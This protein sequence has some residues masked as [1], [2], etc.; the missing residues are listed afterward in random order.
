MPH[1][2]RP[3][4]LPPDDVLLTFDRARGEYLHL[5][6]PVPLRALTCWTAPATIPLPL[7]HTWGAALKPISAQYSPADFHPFETATLSPAPRGEAVIS[8]LNH[9]LEVQIVKTLG[10]GT[11]QARATDVANHIRATLQRLL[12]PVVVTI[13]QPGLGPRLTGADA[14]RWLVERGV[15]DAAV[16][17]PLL[18]GLGAAADGRTPKLGRSG[19][20]VLA[21]AGNAGLLTVVCTPDVVQAAQLVA[22]MAPHHD[23]QARWV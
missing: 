2:A 6:L 17:G 23:P 18:E 7:D 5:G 13:E 19:A 22:V 3:P 1:P 8:I 14:Q 11:L 16:L 12:R 15:Q 9:K 20:N 10:P 21:V 4:A